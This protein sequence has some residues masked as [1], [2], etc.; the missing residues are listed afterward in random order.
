[1]IWGWDSVNKVWVKVLVT[2]AG[3]IKIKAA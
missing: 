2:A 1:M 3:A